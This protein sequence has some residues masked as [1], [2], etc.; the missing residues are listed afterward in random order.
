MRKKGFEMNFA[1]IFS[2]IVGAAILFLAI[3]FAARFMGVGET[4]GN[5]EAATKLAILIDPLETSIGET[6][7]SLISFN[8]NVRIYNDRCEEQGNFGKQTIG[9]ALAR[10]GGKWSDA[11]YGKPQYNKY[12]FSNELEEGKEVYIFVKP[13]EMPFKV[14]DLLIFISQDYC[15]ID[16]PEEI[17]DELKD[18]N[19]EK[20]QFTD[21]KSNCSENSNK[22][23]FGSSSGCNISVYGEYGFKKGYVSK[24]ERK[25]DYVDNLLYAAIFSSPEAY[26]CNVERL[27]KRLINLCLIYKDK[28]SIL[29]S[30]GCNSELGSHLDELVNL[31]GNSNLVNIQEKAEQIE[32]INSAAQC[33]LW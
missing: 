21:K 31:A 15:F 32:I 10:F 14:S 23:C 29:Q 19:I 30:N 16:A 18:M 4:T 5:A 33:N 3:Y 1:W 12:I 20:F 8:S 28:I 7:S 22:V 25:L 9:I 17:E 26:E 27:K 13:F 6:R 24:E 2:I 11:T